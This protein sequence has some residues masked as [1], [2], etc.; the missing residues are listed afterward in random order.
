MELFLRNERMDVLSKLSEPL[1]IQFW[2]V[3]LGVW[4]W[5][6]CQWS[7][8]RVRPQHNLPQLFQ[9]NFKVTF[10]VAGRTACLKT[11]WNECKYVSFTSI[12]QIKHLVRF[13]RHIESYPYPS[14]GR[15]NEN[16]NHRKLNKLITS[17]TALSNSAKLWVMP[18]RAIQDGWVIV[19]SSDKM[20][21][22]GGGNGKTLLYSCF[23]NPMNSMKGKKIWHWKMNSPGW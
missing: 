16:H 22:I 8:W 20:W 19:E 6:S 21:S 13:K 5:R 18:C 11:G 4:I 1:N 14:E 15:E 7:P 10:Q 9:S 17:T 2:S 23:E 12:S 3:A